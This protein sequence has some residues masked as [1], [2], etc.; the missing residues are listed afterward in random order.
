MRVVYQNETENFSACVATVGF[1]DGVHAGHRFLIEELKSL[2]HSQNLKSVVVT[3]SSHPRKVLNFNFQ[4]DLLTTLSEKLIQLE[5]TGIDIC[6][7][8]EFTIEMANLSA[9]EFLK[10]ILSEQLNVRT[11]LVGHDHRFGHNRTDG[12]PE[13]KNFG[14]ML[15]IDVIQATRYKTIDDKHI[16]SSEIRLAL[17]KGD[18]EHA[19]RLLSY[20]YFIRGK[21]VEGFKVGQKIGFPTANI[22][23]EDN[24]KLIPAIGVYAVRVRRNNQ[25][26]KGMMNIGHRPTL[27][28]GDRITIEVHIID[29]NMDIYRETLE[30]DFIRKI[31]D[32]QKFGSIDEL[33]KQLQK[34]KLDVMEKD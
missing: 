32:E 19:N 23:P 9:Y 34:D 29:F 7:V 13:Y 15:G 30:I 5:S 21:V 25:I 17:Q 28:N 12:F 14:Q 26:Y 18:I 20:K 33:I 3:F 2:A 4:P 10:T 22:E 11:L 31:R 27:N 16:S 6:V 1:F 8:L 24:C